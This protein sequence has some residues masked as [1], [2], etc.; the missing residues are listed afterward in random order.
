MKRLSKHKYVISTFNEIEMFQEDKHLVFSQTEFG[1]LKNNSI[2]L[3]KSGDSFT[4]EIENGAIQLVNKTTEE[5]DFAFSNFQ[6]INKENSYSC[7]P[8]AVQNISVPFSDKKINGTIH[9]LIKGKKSDFNNKYLRFVQQISKTA[10]VG[11]IS[12]AI[13]LNTDQEIMY[14][15]GIIRL[16]VSNYSIDIFRVSKDKQEFIFIDSIQPILIEKFEII[17]KAFFQIYSY[18]FG[19]SCGG[20]SYITSSN[21]PDFTVTDKIL[22]NRKQDEKILENYIFDSNEIRKY[23]FSKS[24]FQFP[25]NVF[26][27]MCNK[28][29]TEDKYQRVINIIHEANLNEYSLST[30]ILLS[31]ALETI[32]SLIAKDGNNSKSPIE[33]GTFAESEII[34]KL[35]EKIEE[36]KI[37]KK[38]DKNFLIEKR[39]PNLNKPTN[40]DKLESPFIKYKISLPDNF[41]KALKY[42]DKYLHG[43]IPKG[44][45][46]GTF[47]A[48]NLNR[49]FELQFL[50]NV[51]TLKYVGYTGFLKNCSTE[52]EYYAQKE[53][54]KKDED[55]VINQS[56]YYKI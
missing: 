47:R 20:E 14:G 39:L 21:N 37:L 3:L 43:S 27:N 41:K 23:E 5:L 28:V 9:S 2:R 26:S 45:K 54:G 48:N 25:C 31:S 1:W 42:R 6:L 7:L 52:M 56:L 36:N 17:V 13:D 30:C 19:V 10:K 33:V 4:F 50:V 22:F 40:V 55:I 8:Y 12:G 49:A 15:V 34:E 35:K 53:Q 24:L 18:I 11:C 44:N 38:E 32:S 16:T 46:L 51:L 29:I